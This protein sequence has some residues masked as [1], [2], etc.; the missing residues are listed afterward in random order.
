MTSGYSEGHSIK[1]GGKMA[2]LKAW[3]SLYPVEPVLYN[4]P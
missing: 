1:R 3:Y 4:E 2:F